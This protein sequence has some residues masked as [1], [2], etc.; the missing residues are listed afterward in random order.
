MTTRIVRLARILSLAL[1]VS[2][3]LVAC[4]SATTETG[5]AGITGPVAENGIPF[6]GTLTGKAENGIIDLT[7]PAGAKASSIHT[8]G[9]PAPANAVNGTL[10]LGNGKIVTLTGTYDST[11][12]TVTL[13]GGGYTLTG[14][15]VGGTLS[16]T[17]T[18]PNGGG[19]FAVQSTVSGAVAVYCGT[20]T[21]SSAGSWNLVRGGDN[22]L[23]GSFTDAAN[24]Q[25]GILSGKLNGTDI[26]LNPQGSTDTA[27][28][29]LAG[30][31]VSG[32]YGPPGGTPKGTW[33][34]STGACAK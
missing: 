28:G 12:G 25:S 20:Y 4:S 30:D 6:R 26:L 7:M 32:T 5:D 23:S 18:G 9:D 8:L 3:P 1:V 27:V 16:G 33:S 2:A 31:A 17:Y 19:S 14:K 24:G 21:G 10:N 15:L 22:T 13:S 34:G 29:T 11:T